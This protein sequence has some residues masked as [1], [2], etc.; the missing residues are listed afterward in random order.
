MKRYWSVNALKKSQRRPY[1]K[2]LIILIDLD[3]VIADQIGGFFSILKSEHPDIALPDRSA[4]TEFDIEKNFPEPYRELVRSIRLRAGFFENLPLIQGAVEGLNLIS[5]FA[6]DVRIVTSPIWEWKHC[7]SEKYAWVAQNLGRQW[8]E[9]VI[10]TR[11]KT[12]VRGDILIDDAPSVIG[13]LPPAWTH[14][15]YD[16]PYN[17]EVQ[18]LERMSWSS[19]EAAM[20][21]IQASLN[22]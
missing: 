15:L 17:R 19:V 12:F 22:V 7:V 8:T 5:N 3:N 1:E 14:V 2:P 20:I 9:K 13:S 6:D 18:H 10:L 11:D 4:L 21:R 16:Q